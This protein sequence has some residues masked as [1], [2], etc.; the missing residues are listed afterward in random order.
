M[1]H[2]KMFSEDKHDLHKK[3]FYNNRNRLHK[4][5]FSAQKSY[6]FPEQRTIIFIS[7]D[8]RFLGRSEKK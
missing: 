7:F 2:E 1:L 5:V 3:M 4:K 8:F 6:F